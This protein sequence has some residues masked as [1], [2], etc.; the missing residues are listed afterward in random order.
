MFIFISN[1]ISEIKIEKALSSCEK[2]G[3]DI[4]SGRKLPGLQYADNVLPLNKDPSETQ[5]FVNNKNDSEDMFRMRFAS[6]KC[7]MFLD[8]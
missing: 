1:F 8:D 6:L 3:F 5:A 2:N 4:F 7:K